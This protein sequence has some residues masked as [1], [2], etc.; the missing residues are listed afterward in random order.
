MSLALVIAGLVWAL[1]R[2]AAL[3][4]ESFEWA[5][6]QRRSIPNRMPIA[7]HEARKERT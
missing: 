3:S 1:C 4:D 7:R 5:E 6:L 2:M